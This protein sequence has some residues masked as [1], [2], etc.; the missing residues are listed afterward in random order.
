MEETVYPLFFPYT[1]R[2]LE[3]LPYNNRGGHRKQTFN[4]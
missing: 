1:Y 4:E 2:L 3:K